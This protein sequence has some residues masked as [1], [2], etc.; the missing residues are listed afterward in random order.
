MNIQETILAKRYAASYMLSGKAGHDK[1]RNDLL[2]VYKDISPY[3]R[4]L[5]HP[6]VS[7]Q[8]KHEILKKILPERFKNT[9][10]EN[11]IKVLI[12]SKRISIF[13]LIA[14][15]VEKFYNEAKGIV[16]VEIFSRFELHESEEKALESVF[17]RATG[18]KIVLK[19]NLKPELLGGLQV[20]LKDVFM[21]N[22]VK[23]RLEHLK[24]NFF[25]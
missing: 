4:Y 2:E 24:K 15:E 7:A 20:R 23:T 25:N 17:A 18:K 3:V 14:R 6:C 10:A 16:E 5:S 9:H 11:L 21:D 12:D 1:S 13:G 8:I 22:S 19:K